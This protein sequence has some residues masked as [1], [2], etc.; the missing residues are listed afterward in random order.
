VKLQRLRTNTPEISA[1]HPPGE[2]T[3]KQTSTK[4]KRE[5]GE[6]EMLH[7]RNEPRFNIQEGESWMVLGA[8]TRNM[9]V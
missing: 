4:I 5:K 9:D 2:I 1:K 7:E 6:E 8:Q 3:T